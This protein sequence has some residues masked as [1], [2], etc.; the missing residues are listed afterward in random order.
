MGNY[1]YGAS[2][3]FTVTLLINIINDMIP[4]DLGYYFSL[5][6]PF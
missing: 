6:M 5:L 3:M 4:N 2:T 1:I